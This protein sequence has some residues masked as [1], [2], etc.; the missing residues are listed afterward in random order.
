MKALLCVDLTCF[1]FLKKLMIDDFFFFFLNF[2]N[3][4][5]MIFWVYI[6]TLEL[7]T[8]FWVTPLVFLLH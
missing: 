1:L 2:S 8:M 7:A 4:V 3:S 5:Y 6:T